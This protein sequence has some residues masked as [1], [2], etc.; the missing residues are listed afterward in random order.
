MFTLT[1]TSSLRHSCV[2]SRTSPFSNIFLRVITRR[3]SHWQERLRH[4]TV[5]FRRGTSP[6]SNIFSCVITRGCSH[7]QERL[8]HVTVPFRH[9]TSPFSNIFSRVITRRCSHW[10]NGSEPVCTCSIPIMWTVLCL[11]HYTSSVC[12]QRVL[13]VFVFKNGWKI[14]GIGP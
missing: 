12:L 3:C 8:R 11:L 7:W 1:G 4:I 5:P 2:P 6:F 10:R 13:P 9:G 14:N